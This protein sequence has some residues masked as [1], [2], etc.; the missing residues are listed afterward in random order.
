MKDARGRGHGVELRQMETER[1]SAG[2]CH[3]RSEV[4][5]GEQKHLINRAN[6]GE[7]Y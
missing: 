3:Q 1:R 7:D 4:N 2:S 6:L 5:E